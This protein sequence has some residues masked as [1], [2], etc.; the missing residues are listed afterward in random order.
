MS[1]VLGIDELLDVD[2]LNTLESISKNQRGEN[3]K[4]RSINNRI[5]LPKR[6]SSVSPYV[7]LTL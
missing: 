1:K 2:P 4:D 5:I 7:I 6:M 3:S